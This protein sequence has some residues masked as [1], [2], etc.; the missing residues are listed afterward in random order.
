MPNR[1]AGETS[2]YLQQH[3]DNP[4]DWYPWGEEAWERARSEDRPVLVS[5]GYSS[6][7]WCHVMEHE[8]FC[9]DA[10]AAVMN[11]KLVCIKVDREERPDVD[12][13]YMDTIVRLTGQGGWPLNVF[14]TPDARP[15]FGGTYFPPQPAHGRPSW[16][17]IVDAVARSYAEQRDDMTKQAE[18]ILQALEA[19]PELSTTGAPGADTLTA[20]CADVMARADAAHGGFG[21]A[22][23]FPTP[24]NLEAILLGA[25]R[26]ASTAGALEHVVFSLKRMA[27]GGIYDQL[28]GGFHR[29][30]TDA[31]WLVPHFEKMLYD[32]GQLLRVY[33]EA[34]RQTGDADLAWPVAE[35]IAYLAR[36]MRSPE[37]GFYASQD[38][39]SEGEEGKFYVW[40]RAEVEAVIGAEQGTPFC[41]AYGV[42]PGGSFERTGKSVLEHA[43]AGERPRFA[44]ARA[45]L[46]AARTRRIPP[47]TDP[48]QIAAWISYAVGGIATA[49]AEFERGDWLEL[50]CEA[51]DFV[52]EHM[53]DPTHGLLR[54]YDQGRASVPAFLD[55]HG[56]LLCA[57]L[58]LQ[59]A[60]AD[61]HFMTAALE[62]ADAIRDRFFDRDRGDVFLSRAGDATLILRPASDSDGATPAA[63]GLATLGLVRIG[64]LCEREDLLQVA[65]AV[66]A[67]Q[68]PLAQRVPAATP[69]LL[70]AAALREWGLGVALVLG[71]RDDERTQ[72][73][74]RRARALLSSESAVVLA[75]PEQP[76]AWL[77]RGWLEGRTQT[78][79]APTAYLCRGRVC[80]L[81]ATTPDTLTL[82]PG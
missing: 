41:E 24:T 48:K 49:A 72:A 17:Q 69:T 63:N 70:R 76:P 65:D 13:I 46:Y 28:G 44:S 77:G 14:C 32:Q 57:L 21:A 67:T 7:H 61:D 16:T 66:L 2:V 9:D 42:V 5:I 54:I 3:R 35:T 29:Y 33:A 78:D 51:A 34:H 81:P 68:G 30:S 15:F 80:S 47:L 64:E 58:D 6:C 50:A 55:D 73:L 43:L 39:D 82:P 56:A 38:A 45:E 60:G 62:I 18:Q 4:V 23:K 20:F 8:S 71:A 36:E 53:R 31:R 37:G 22:P 79:G 40:D 1:L 25:T 11:S 52:L 26:H 27:R 19:R 12:Q 10:V 75:A 59:R 74:A